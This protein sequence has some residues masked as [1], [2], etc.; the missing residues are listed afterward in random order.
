MQKFMAFWTQDHIQAAK[1]IL[2]LAAGIAALVFPEGPAKKAAEFVAAGG[3]TDSTLGSLWKM[4]Q[5]KGG[6]A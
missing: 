5:P 1:K 4:L 6:A 2:V 3:L